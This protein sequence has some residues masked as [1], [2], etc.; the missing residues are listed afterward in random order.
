PGGESGPTNTEQSGAAGRRRRLQRGTKRSI[1]RETAGGRSARRGARLLQGRGRRKGRGAK[2]GWKGGARDHFHGSSA[3][4]HP[5]VLAG[6][7][8]HLG[9]SPEV[10]KGMA[11]RRPRRDPETGPY[12]DDKM[13]ICGHA[14]LSTTLSI[15]PITAGR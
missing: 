13:G 2:D 4:K 10:N 1:V 6:G 15:R 11:G 12:E 14:G 9:D 7:A 8:R 3:N 5:V